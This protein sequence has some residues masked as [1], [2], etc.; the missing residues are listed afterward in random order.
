MIAEPTVVYPE[1]A[2]EEAVIEG[3][4]EILVEAGRKYLLVRR[5]GLDIAVFIE[6]FGSVLR[7]SPELTRPC[8]SELT[9]R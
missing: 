3:V 6:A 8:S 4:R 1:T 5:F 7:R 2:F 9:H